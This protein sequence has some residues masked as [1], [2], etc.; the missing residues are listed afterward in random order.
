MPA[1]QW[2]AQGFETSSAGGRYD[3]QMR[4]AIIGLMGVVLGELITAFGTYG[5]NAHTKQASSIA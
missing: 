3:R 4:A 2:T 5:W 1:V